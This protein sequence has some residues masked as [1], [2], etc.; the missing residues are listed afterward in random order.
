M[1]VIKF[2]YMWQDGKNWL[3]H[4]HTLDAIEGGDHYDDMSDC[5]LLRNYR[6][7]ARRQFTGLL[8]KNSKEIYKQDWIKWSKAEDVMLVDFWYGKWVL[9]HRPTCRAEQEG[10]P[11]HDNLYDF[12]PSELEIIGNIYENPELLKP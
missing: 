12:D 9:V 1:R 5:P 6:V 4:V 10:E 2:S 11:L 3:E 8:D 7:K